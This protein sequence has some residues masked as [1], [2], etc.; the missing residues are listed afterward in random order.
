MK[1]WKLVTK[2]LTLLPIAQCA[3]FSRPQRG[4]S[5][6]IELD[7]FEIYLQMVKGQM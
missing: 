2:E 1:L 7:L 6:V 5:R 3:G 4:L